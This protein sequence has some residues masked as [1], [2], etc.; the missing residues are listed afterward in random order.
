MLVAASARGDDERAVV[1]GELHRTRQEVGVQVGLRDD[2]DPQAGLVEDGAHGAQVTRRVDD[3]R[4]SP[5]EIG[6]VARRTQVLV[7]DPGDGQSPVRTL[8]RT[9]AVRSRTTGTAASPGSPGG[10]IRPVVRRGPVGAPRDG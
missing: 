8:V 6:D 1:V 4:R 3:Q 5:T 7:D 9:H 2:A 10:G